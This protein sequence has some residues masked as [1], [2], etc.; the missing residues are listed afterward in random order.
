VEQKTIASTY[1]D[2]GSDSRDESKIMAIGSKDISTINSNSSVQS[3][4]MESDIDQKKRRELFHVRVIVNHAKV[5]TL[6]ENGSQVNVI[7][8]AI[9]KNLGL[10]T[11]LHKNPYPLGVVCDDAKLQVTK[12]CNIMFAITTKLFDEARLDVVALYICGIVLGLV[13]I[14]FT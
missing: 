9:V 6:F 3:T 2:L 4:K 14:Y 7:S 12:Q 8:E 11:T 5:D 10:K 13:H 1:Q